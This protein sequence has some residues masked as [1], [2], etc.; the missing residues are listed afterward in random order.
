MSAKKEKRINNKSRIID[1]TVKIYFLGFRIQNLPR[2]LIDPGGL[3]MFQL[4][5]NIQYYHITKS[6]YPRSTHEQFDQKAGGHRTYLFGIHDPKQ[7]PN[8]YYNK[9]SIASSLY[10]QRSH[11]VCLTCLTMTSDEKE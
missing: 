9:N 8:K 10:T 11:T 6:L 5:G 2:Y 1:R 4:L 3:Q 7:V